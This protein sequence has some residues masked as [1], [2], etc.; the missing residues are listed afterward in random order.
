MTRQ[1]YETELVRLHGRRAQ[2][3]TDLAMVDQDI[4]RLGADY[5]NGLVRQRLAVYVAEEPSAMSDCGGGS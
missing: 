3:A 5:L 1:D 2:L 4:A